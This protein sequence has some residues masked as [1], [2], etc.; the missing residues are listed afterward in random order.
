MIFFPTSTSPFLYLKFSNAFESLSLKKIWAYLLF[1]R[2]SYCT[3][4]LRN[5]TIY[6]PLIDID[7]LFSGSTGGVSGSGGIYTAGYCERRAWRNQSTSSLFLIMVELKLGTK[8][9]SMVYEPPNPKKPPTFLIYT[10]LHAIY[11]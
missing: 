4:L 2:W 9:N 1:R 7:F 5:W 8:V 6:L 10:P 11:G 3:R